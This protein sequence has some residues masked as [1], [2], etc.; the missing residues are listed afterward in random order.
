MRRT[1]WGPAVGLCAVLLGSPGPSLAHSPTVGEA[2]AEVRS[3]E[4]RQPVGV[5]EVEQSQELGRMLVIRVGEGWDRA[6]AARR[7][8]AAERWWT[9]WRRVVDNGIVAVVDHASQASRVSYDRQGRA[10]LTGPRAEDRGSAQ[11]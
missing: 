8:A 9:S 11:P 3:G 10:Q 1:S 5:V 6:P 2:I 7:R 4:A